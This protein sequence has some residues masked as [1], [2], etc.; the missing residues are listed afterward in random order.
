MRKKHTGYKIIY[1]RYAEKR[2]KEKRSKGEKTNAMKINCLTNK[3]TD[4][5][6]INSKSVFYRGILLQETQLGNTWILWILWIKARLWIWLKY[7][8]GRTTYSGNAERGRQR[9]YIHEGREHRWKQSGIRDDIGPVTQEEGQVT[10]SEWRVNFQNKTWNSQDR[11]P[12][13]RHPS[14]RCDTLL[15]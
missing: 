5:N 2:K 4:Q 3:S 8:T 9:L 11:K 10:Y 12:M 14:P 7:S 6:F 15:S 1:T 13:T